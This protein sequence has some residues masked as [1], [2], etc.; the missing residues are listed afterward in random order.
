MRLPLTIDSGLW[1]HGHCQGMQVNLQKGEIYFSFTTAFVRMKLDGTLL[2]SVE[3][4]R[5]HL[6]CIALEKE[7]GR[8]FASLEYKNDAIGRG[9]LQMLGD[10][11]EL[12]DGFYIAVFEPEKITRKGLKPDEND[13]MKTVFLKKPTEDYLWESETGEKHRYGASGIDGV[14]FAPAFGENGGKN[15]LF[16]A[17][18]IYGNVIRLDNDHQ[19]ILKYDTSGW[20]KYLTPAG[21]ES[22]HTN[23]PDA[24]DSVYF[25]FTGNTTYGIQNLEY[26]AYSN[27][28][29]CAVYPGIKPEYP[30]Y[31]MYALDALR[32]PEI[33]PLK[34]LGGETGETVFLKNASYTQ[35]ASGI[36]GLNF[37]YG[38]TGLCALGNGYYYISEPENTPDG[39]RTTVRLYEFDEK[40]LFVPAKEE[41]EA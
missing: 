2:G 16:T 13:C 6:G 22:L 19:V 10:E 3:G 40:L 23:G 31:S 12:T 27:A 26:D 38:S 1:K 32:K 28:L 37:P 30:N 5:G 25:A 14:T 39:Y 34:G 9:I 15:Y 17:Y 20:E 33:L 7:T 18:G 8:V 11:N 35:E 4:L 24:P 41:K 29:F 36:P 21:A